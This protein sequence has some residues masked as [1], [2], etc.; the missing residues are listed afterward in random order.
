MNLLPHVVNGVALGVLFGLLALGFM[1]IV[2]VMEVINL[3]HGS[4]FALG[5]YLAME[6]ISPRWL[7][8]AGES[9]SA[10]PLALRYGL[11]LVLAPL[12]ILALRHASFETA[13][14]AESDFAPK[15]DNDEDDE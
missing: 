10:L 12:L 13:R 9:F 4:M 8:A 2:G 1:L 14:K 15:A 3:A 11:A 6:I 5:A 7:G